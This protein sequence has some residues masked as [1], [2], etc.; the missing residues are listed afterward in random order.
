M[1]DKTQPETAFWLLSATAQSS[2]AL[3][4]LS[5]LLWVFFMRGFGAEF[6]RPFS[7]DIREEDESE[8][9]QWVLRWLTRFSSY[10]TA[11]FIAALAVSLLTLGSVNPGPSPVPGFQVNLVWLSVGLTLV[12]GAMMVVFVISAHAM[13]FREYRG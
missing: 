1:E 2:A 8:E 6:R 9:R 13:L 3:A 12:A 4:C 10:S 5:A 11:V 7:E